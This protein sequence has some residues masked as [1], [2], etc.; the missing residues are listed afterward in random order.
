[1][2]LRLLIPARAIAMGPMRHAVRRFLQ[3][4]RVP[5]DRGD[6][7]VL[8]IDEACTNICRH[9]YPEARPGLIRLH[10]RAGPRRLRVVIRDYGKPIP[11]RKLRGRRL[12]RPAPGGLGIH[13][14]RAAFPGIRF[15][16][17]PRGTRLVLT[18]P[19]KV[20]T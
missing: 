11:R 18:A 8:A 17:C 7:I 12:D 1:M 14:M 5:E 19:A 13:L 3:R 6:L 10:L 15:E 16:P 2:D 20:R 9:A 4:A